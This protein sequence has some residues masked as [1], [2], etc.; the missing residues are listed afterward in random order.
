M[1]VRNVRQTK[2]EAAKKEVL[3]EE[4]KWKKVKIVDKA[5]VYVSAEFKIVQI[6][7]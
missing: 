5:N 1:S 7:I 6:F 3:E 4:K 2:V